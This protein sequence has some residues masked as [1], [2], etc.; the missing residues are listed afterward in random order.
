[1]PRGS[2]GRLEP[3]LRGQA[4]LHHLRHRALDHPGA[5]GEE[6]RERHHAGRDGAADETL[7]HTLDPVS[8]GR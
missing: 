2:A 6:A 7:E 8:H 5:A 1:M 3:R 4:F